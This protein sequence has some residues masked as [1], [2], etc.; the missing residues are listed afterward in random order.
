MRGL[1]QGKFREKI[2]EEAEDILSENRAIDDA[3][4]LA[5]RLMKKLNEA[6]MSEMRSE[7]IAEMKRHLEQI[8]KLLQRV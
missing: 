7:E 5:D 2:R 3:K 1:K 8:M 4:T 6:Q